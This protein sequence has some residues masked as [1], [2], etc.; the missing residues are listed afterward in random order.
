MTRS[1][2]GFTLI[3]LL[4]ASGVFLIGFVAVFGLFLAGVRFR[5]LSDDT[6]RSALAAS[7]LINEIRIDAGREGGT[8]PHEPGDY[9]GDGFAADGAEGYAL[10]P[11]PPPPPAPQPA[12][13]TEPS[14]SFQLFPYPAQPGVW[15]RVV[16]CTDFIGDPAGA[17]TTALRLRLLVLPW[18]QAEDA[19]AFDLLTVNQRIGLFPRA[20]TPTGAQMIAELTKRGLAFEY[21]A[22]IIRHPSWR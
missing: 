21:H 9:V 8:A 14:D 22:T 6:A 7:S 20:S 10:P 4:V 15:Y 5:K 13:D 12:A 18:S 11:I 17:D 19:T 3:E 2:D 1:R 16:T